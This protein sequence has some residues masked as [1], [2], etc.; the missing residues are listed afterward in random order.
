MKKKAEEKLQKTE[1]RQRKAE[2]KQEEARRKAMEKER[3]AAEKRNTLLEKDVAKRKRG[4][5]HLKC[6]T[7]SQNKENV[8]DTVPVSVS[9]EMMAC[10]VDQQNECSI[11]M[12]K[13]EDYL[14]DSE[15]QNEWICCTGCSC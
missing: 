6:M 2:V 3:K 15:L 13:Y 8:S 12:G 5:G 11:Y 10:R 14:I 1:E 7:H 4:K 9:S